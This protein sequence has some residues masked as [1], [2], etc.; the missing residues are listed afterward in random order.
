[1]DILCELR[2][3]CFPTNRMCN[4]GSER[5]QQFIDGLNKF[6]EFNKDNEFDVLITDNTISD[7]NKLP[8]E[9]LDILPEK[10]KIITCL[11]NN[12][13]CINKGSGLIEQWNYNKDFIKIYEWL[14]YFEPRQLLQ[15]NNFINSFLENPRNLFTMG[16]GNNHFNTGLFCIEIKTLLDYINE[17]SPKSLVD[18]T[19]GIE[20]SI[21]NYFIRNNIK[22]DTRNKMELIWY[23]VMDIHNPFRMM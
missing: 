20:Y 23:D 2:L 6:F 7:D 13:G 21:Y 3:C 1:M 4:S 8:Q 10:C 22:F 19:E 16:G 11:N 12:Y 15:T 18:R 14:I 5:I 9:I 17:V